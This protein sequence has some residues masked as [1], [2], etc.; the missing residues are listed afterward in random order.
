[1]VDD[2][3]LQ[4]GMNGRNRDG[5]LVSQLQWQGDC[6]GGSR[7]CSTGDFNSTTHQINNIFSDSH[8]QAC[9]FNTISI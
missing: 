4:F 7:A 9:A 1:M 8:T 2:Q 6:K 5:L 3:G